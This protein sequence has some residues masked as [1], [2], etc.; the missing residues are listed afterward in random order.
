MTRAASV[1]AL[2]V[3]VSACG[4]PSVPP[5]RAAPTRLVLAD[6]V[7]QLGAL[8]REPMVVRHPSG[9]LFVTGYW[10]T[11][12]P[13]WKSTDNGASWTKLDVGSAAN[14]AVG[15]SD[16]DLAVGPDG[17]VYLITLVFGRT[18]FRGVSIQVA[19]S[20]DVG[21]TWK[22]TQVAKADLVDRPWID[23]APD[24][25]VHAI[26]NDGAGVRRVMSADTGRTWTDQ[27]R[28]N[29]QGGSSHLAV[30]P[31]GEV[32]VRMIPPSAAN[33]AYHPGVDLVAVSTDRGATWARHPG[34][35]GIAFRL[36]WDTTVTPRRFDP[37]VQPHWV[38]PLAWDSTGALYSLWAKDQDLWLGRSADRGVTWRSWR[39]ASSDSI[40]YYPYLIAGGAGRLA[41][42]WMTGQGAALH[43][44][45]ALIQIGA[46]SAPPAVVRAPAFQ[47][48]SF[49][50]PGFGAAGAREPAGEYFPMVFLPD[51]TLGVVTPIQNT[52]TQ[53]M[54]FT[55]RRYAPGPVSGVYP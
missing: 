55:W 29:D 23:A 49:T 15:N 12:P 43:A 9:A 3:L 22:W 40:P 5:P 8:A 48:E 16:S 1:L 26:W 27:G 6:S 19:V 42:S 50:L 25:M 38:E 41:A 18:T 36:M 24:G 4:K 34:P 20:H 32:A 33:L 2:V 28:V 30:G 45:L 37:G 14:G 35:G 17:S 44:N 31:N 54:G 39:I 53:R 13:V 7:D 52:G 21:A 47:F 51:G 11:I 10:D 46:D